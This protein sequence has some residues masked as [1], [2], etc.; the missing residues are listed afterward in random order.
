MKLLLRSG[1]DPDPRSGYGLTPLALAA[2][3]GHTEI[4]E[5]LLQKGETLLH[6]MLQEENTQGGGLSCQC[7]KYLMG[8]CK[9][10]RARFFSVVPHN[11][12][13]GNGHQLKPSKFCLNI[14]KHFFL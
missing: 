1:A 4:M 12:T 14:R 11:R 7:Y 9:E 10:D 6:R 13:R 5:L 2:Q 8:W 3:I